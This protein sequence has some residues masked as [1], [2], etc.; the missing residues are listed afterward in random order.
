M[1]IKN[2]LISQNAPADF[3]KSP[4]ADLKKKYSINIDFF[5]FFQVEG[6][7]S[8]EFRDS[9][10]NILEHTAVIFAS[11]NAIDYFFSLVKELRLDISEEMKYFCTTDAIAFYLQK[12]IQFRKRKIFFNK[13]NSPKGLFDLLLKNADHKFLIPCG[14]D[15]SN[16]QYTDFFKEHNIAY[17]QAVIFKTVPANL[18]EEVE[19]DKYNMIVFFSPFGIQSLK[20]NFPEFKQGEVAIGA[21]GES[22]VAAIE[23]E[24]FTVHVKAPTKE[25]PSITA[26]L[27]IF[28]KE[29]ATRKR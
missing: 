28:L 24:G 7:S 8:R 25:T 4:Y 1:K 19:I 6:I 27:D 29:H 17:N 11:R 12:Y 21:L 23:A 9:K 16:T 22:A 26:A 3:E 15:S 18:K 5:K 10:I 13:N 2:I 14:A 20:Y